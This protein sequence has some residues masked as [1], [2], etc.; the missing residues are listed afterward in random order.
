MLRRVGVDRV[1]ARSEMASETGVEAHLPLSPASAHEL[2]AAQQRIVGRRTEVVA[3]V[4]RRPERVSRPG[5]RIVTRRANVL[6]QR[7]SDG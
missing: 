4:I 6:R 1:R 5:R 7:V 3:S 2:V